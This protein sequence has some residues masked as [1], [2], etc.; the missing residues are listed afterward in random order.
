MKLFAK[1]KGRG[2]RLQCAFLECDNS[3]LGHSVFSSFFVC[4]FALL[5]L[6]FIIYKIVLLQI[7]QLHT[8]L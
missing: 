6:V 8:T 3:I 7:N 1:V 4:D 2:I 5:T